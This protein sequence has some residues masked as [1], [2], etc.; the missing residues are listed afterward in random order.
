[1]TIKPGTLI[2]LRR[3]RGG[4][5]RSLRQAWRYRAIDDDINSSFRT[6][7]VGDVALVLERNNSFLDW[8]VYTI[9]IDGGKAAFAECYLEPLGQNVK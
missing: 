5:R 3:G 6:A 9:L 4:K 2:R 1:M 7:N 8:P